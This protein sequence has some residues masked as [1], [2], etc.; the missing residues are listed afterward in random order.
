M[1]THVTRP[2]MAKTSRVYTPYDIHFALTALW[3]LLLTLLLDFSNNMISAFQKY[4][5][6]LSINNRSIENL[7][8]ILG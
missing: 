2:V 3:W 6:I 5:K 7:T 4:N 1:W 8:S